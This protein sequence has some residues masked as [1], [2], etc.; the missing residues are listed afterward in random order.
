[1]KKKKQRSAVEVAINMGFIILAHTHYG[2]KAR[3]G[4]YVVKQSNGYLRDFSESI[5]ARRS[6]QGQ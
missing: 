3:V 5:N 4:Q 1:M 2:T 6:T